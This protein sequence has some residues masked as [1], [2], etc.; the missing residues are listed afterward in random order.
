M[1]YDQQITNLINDLKTNTDVI[2]P[3]KNYA[4]SDLLR[5]QAVIRMGKTTSNLTPP[6][7][8]QTCTCPFPGRDV[9]C[10]VHGNNV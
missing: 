4:V 3:Y 5:V 6:T 1:N 7:N 8:D 10:L 2:Q 9:N